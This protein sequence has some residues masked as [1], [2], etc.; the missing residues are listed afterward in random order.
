MAQKLTKEEK[1]C[2]NVNRLEQGEQ[3]LE[4]EQREPAPEDVKVIAARAASDS[5]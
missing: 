2:R 1:L 3:T 5:T 4:R